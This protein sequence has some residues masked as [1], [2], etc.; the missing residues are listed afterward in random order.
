MRPVK[1]W[2]IDAFTDRP[3]RGNSAAVC[4]LEEDVAEDWMQSVAAEMNLAETAFVQRQSEGYRL[5]WFTPLVE[6]PLCGHATLASAHALWTERL[7][8]R[9]QPI[10]FHTQSGLL[11]C[12]WQNELITMDFPATPATAVEPP[13]GLLESLRVTPIFVGK[14]QFDHLVVVEDA[15][16]VRTLAPDLERLKAVATRGVMVTS[17]SDDPQYDFI[18]RFFAPAVGINEDPVTGSAHCCL[19]PYWATELGKTSL[20]ALQASA[21]EG[22]IQVQVDQERVYLGGQAVTVLRGELV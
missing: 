20:T 5:R 19:G 10:H 18:S 15:Q 9:D 22:A 8:A 11:T 17:L 12:T 1:C 3:F 13:V 6:V 2:Q 21:R 14:T 4:W 7:H 16:Q